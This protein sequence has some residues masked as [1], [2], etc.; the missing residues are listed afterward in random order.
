MKRTDSTCQR[1]SLAGHMR[2][3]PPVTTQVVMPVHVSKIALSILL[4]TLYASYFGRYFIEKYFRGGVIIT[5]DEKQA[6]E[7]SSPGELSLNIVLS[8][9]R[10]M[11]Q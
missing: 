7:I 4:F 5:R 2:K 6:D 10:I 11:F 9:E 1:V 8:F 3:K